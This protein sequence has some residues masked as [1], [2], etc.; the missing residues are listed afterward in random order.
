MSAGDATCYLRLLN[1]CYV[2]RGYL[3]SVYEKMDQTVEGVGE[4]IV[5]RVW[6]VER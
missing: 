3:E 2:V 1:P 6:S 5:G 4:L